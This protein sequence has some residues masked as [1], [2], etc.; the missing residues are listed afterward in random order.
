MIRFNK[1]EWINPNDLIIHNIAL[2]NP[3]M[4]EA[5]LDS[6]VVNM[7]LNGFNIKHPILT[8]GETNPKVFDGRNRV[9]AAI[10][11]GIE[12]VPVM[13]TVKRTK[14]SEA[15]EYARTLECRRQMTTTQKAIKA[16]RE[17]QNGEHNSMRQA[18]IINGID[19]NMVRACKYINEDNL[20]M[21]FQ[22]GSIKIGR[23]SYSNVLQLSRAIATA[24]KPKQ[25]A[26]NDS[27][28]LHKTAVKQLVAELLL[29]DSLVVREAVK[30]LSLQ[31]YIKEK[32]IEDA[33]AIRKA[34][35]TFPLE[36][37]NEALNTDESDA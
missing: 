34:E 3:S 36:E 16:Y 18:A 4:S 6:L 11:A 23:Q 15:K 37:K 14:M 30:K 25:D 2:E 26:D 33:V 5:E 9:D 12:L 28:T 21:L 10:R 22:G 19:K 29:K 24:T 17:Y 35:I 27:V 32:E 7:K 20:N 8:F 31:F 1:I 13:K